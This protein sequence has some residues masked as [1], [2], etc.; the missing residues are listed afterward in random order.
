MPGRTVHA[1]QHSRRPGAAEHAARADR[2]RHANGAAAPVEEV[3]VEPETHP[4]RVDRRAA[5]DQQGVAGR[6]LAQE[7][8][9]EEARAEG[10]RLKGDEP[11]ADLVRR[12]S[13]EPPGQ[14]N[15]LRSEAENLAPAV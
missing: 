9:P 3:D 13:P 4:E 11:V 15:R 5:R 7:R 2:R 8:Q 6:Q 1:L 10:A 12:K 14:H